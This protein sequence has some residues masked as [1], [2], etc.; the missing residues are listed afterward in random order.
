MEKRI[1][2]P[3][4]FSIYLL[5]SPSAA[6]RN[7]TLHWQGRFGVCPFILLNSKQYYAIE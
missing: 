2:D 5:N 3:D 4:M 6:D 1:C 7:V